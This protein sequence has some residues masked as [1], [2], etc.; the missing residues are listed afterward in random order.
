[1]AIVGYNSISEALAAIKVSYVLELNNHP[2]GD[3]YNVKVLAPLYENK[4]YYLPQ[5]YSTDV[6]NIHGDVLTQLAIKYGVGK[7]TFYY[8][9]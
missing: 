4:E 5:S 8:I 7:D 3:Y 9:H 1:M 2:S 6:K